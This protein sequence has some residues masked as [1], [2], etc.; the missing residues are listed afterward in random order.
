MSHLVLTLAIIAVKSDKEPIPERRENEATFDKA[1]PRFYEAAPV[2]AKNIC[3]S[4][5]RAPT[6]S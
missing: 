3:A 1:F 4:L 2:A 5:T 6:A